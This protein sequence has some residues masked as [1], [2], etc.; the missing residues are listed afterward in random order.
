SSLLARG[1]WLASH[2]NE[3]RKI[4]RAVLK[5][6]A[7]IREHSAEEI[8]DKVPAEFRVGDRPAEL[9]AIR[10]AKP[11]YSVDGRVRPESAASVKKVLA[12]S[13][14]KV[15]TATIDLSNTYT[16]AYLP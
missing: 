6:L 15:R 16:N 3:A 13:L 1:E 7:W 12:G 8:L 14:E 4:A 5:S 9:E 11:M 10:L 2:P